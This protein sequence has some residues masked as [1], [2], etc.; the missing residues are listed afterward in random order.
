ML[1][2]RKELDE[3]LKALELVQRM[4]V[5]IDDIQKQLEGKILEMIKLRGKYLL[6]RNKKD[7]SPSIKHFYDQISRAE[8][9]IDF[10]DVQ[11]R[12]RGWWDAFD[13]HLVIISKQ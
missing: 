11:S 1:I 6:E 10:D 9:L 4:P 3:A 12:L 13:E 8:E 2:T 5:D 7:G